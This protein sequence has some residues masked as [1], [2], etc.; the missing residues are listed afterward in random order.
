MTRQND[1]WCYLF[2][3]FCAGNCQRFQQ[4]PL[5]FCGVRVSYQKRRDVQRLENAIKLCLKPAEVEQ[6]GFCHEKMKV[7]KILSYYTGSQISVACNQ[8]VR[9]SKGSFVLRLIRQK[10]RFWTTGRRRVE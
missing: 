10:S 7:T 1:V 9:G 8:S 4:E 5:G 6:S 2:S 3:A